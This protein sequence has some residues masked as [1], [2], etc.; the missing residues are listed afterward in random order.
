[1]PPADVFA[2]GNSLE[3][4]AAQ[5][6]SSFKEH[7]ARAVAEVVNFVLRAAGCTLKINEDDVADPDHCADKLGEIQDEYQAVRRSDGRDLTGEC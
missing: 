6:V 4:A 7:E 2:R 5:W 1:L 3:D